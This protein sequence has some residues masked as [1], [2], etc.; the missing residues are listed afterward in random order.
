VLSGFFARI[1]TIPCERTGL[2]ITNPI[3][4][5]DYGTVNEWLTQYLAALT[6]LEGPLDFDASAHELRDWWIQTRPQPVDELLWNYYE[7]GDNLVIKLSMI[8]AVADN[9]RMVVSYQH[10]ETAIALY[11]WMFSQLPAL[12]DFAHR[13]PESEKLEQIAAFIEHRQRVAHSVV[14][15]FATSRGVTREQFKNALDTL[16]ERGD[17]SFGKFVGRSGGR[18]YVWVD[19]A[20][21]NDE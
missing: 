11:E 9:Y 19:A 3:Y 15:R 21:R 6:Y 13:T 16:R 7:H 20:E 1:C 17:I 4:P 12:L 10:V 5:H 8:A 14:L 2:R 18:Q